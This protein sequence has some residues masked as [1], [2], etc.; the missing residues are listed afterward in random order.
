[1]KFLHLL[2][3]LLLEYV[4]DVSKCSRNVTEITLLNDLSKKII[5]IGFDLY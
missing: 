5:V 3:T 4:Q 2:L 1:M